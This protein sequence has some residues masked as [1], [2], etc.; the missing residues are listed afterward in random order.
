M[1]AF[2]QE[3]LDLGVFEGKGSMAAFTTGGD[4]LQVCCIGVA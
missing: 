4:S 1:R 2:D 3:N